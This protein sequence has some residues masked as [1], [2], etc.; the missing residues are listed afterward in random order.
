MKANPDP[1]L[2]Q[3]SAAS[4]FAAPSAAASVAKYPAFMQARVWDTTGLLLRN[5]K[6][7]YHI[8]AIS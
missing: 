7:S 4:D 6:L 3:S 2:I 5:L 8:L 1:R